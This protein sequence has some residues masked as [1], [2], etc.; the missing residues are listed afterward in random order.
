MRRMS[1][2]RMRRLRLRIDLP[3]SKQNFL[4]TW[5]VSEVIRFSNSNSLLMFLQWRPQ[6]TEV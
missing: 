6:P 4:L 2:R 3:V 1:R 5:C